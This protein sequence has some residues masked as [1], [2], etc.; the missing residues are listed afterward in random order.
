MCLSN[1]STFSGVH[2]VLK[3]KNDLLY[4]MFDLSSSRASVE[5]SFPTNTASFLGRT[6]DNIKLH[7][8]REVSHRDSQRYGD[9]AYC[10][11]VQNKLMLCNLIDCYDGFL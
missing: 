2:V 8:G 10:G 9:S 11:L 7:N 1:Y 6:Q 3:V 4:Q 5:S